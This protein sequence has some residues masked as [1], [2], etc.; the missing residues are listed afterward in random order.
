MIIQSPQL[1]QVELWVLHPTLHPPQACIVLTLLHIATSVMRT[2]SNEPGK[3]EKNTLVL[4]DLNLT[5]LAEDKTPP[6]T[7]KYPG[8]CSDLQNSP[9]MTPHSYLNAIRTG[10]D[11]L[12]ASSSWSNELQLCPY[13]AAGECQFGDAH[14]YLHGNMCEIF[15][16]R[17]LHP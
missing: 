4:R 13:A 1:Q 17:F 15:R 16:L 2:H 12:E 5:G 9:E 6:S 10:L 7:V 14:I 11:D 8:G 3:Q